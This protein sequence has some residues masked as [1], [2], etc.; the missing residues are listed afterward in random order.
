MWIYI[1]IAK[2]WFIMNMDERKTVA[3]S[4]IQNI[5]SS[6]YVI[7]SGVWKLFLNILNISNMKAITIPFKIK[8][9]KTWACDIAKLSKI[10]SFI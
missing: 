1:F 7:Q 6:I 10:F 9:R 5:I 4:V 8:I 2:E 3:S